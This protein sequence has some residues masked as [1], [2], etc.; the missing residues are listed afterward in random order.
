MACSAAWDAW[1]AGQPPPHSLGT[2]AE[3]SFAAQSLPQV[4]SRL[5]TLAR[6][7]A[8][9]A[10]QRLVEVVGKRVLVRVFDEVKR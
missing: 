10:E 6:Q 9:A 4:E 3:L 5:Q 7:L 8:A 2:A 1:A